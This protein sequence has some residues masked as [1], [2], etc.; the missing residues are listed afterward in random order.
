[1]M[2]AMLL[3]LASAA[4]A[5]VKVWLTVD[6][7]TPKG[8]QRMLQG[9]ELKS[10]EQFQMQVKVDRKAYVYVVQFFPDGTSQVLFP[11]EGEVTVEAEEQMRL[12]PEGYWFK[13]DTNAGTE[14]IYVIASER[15]ISQADKTTASI[16]DEVRKPKPKP[17]KKL[18]PD[19]LAKNEVGG[20]TM[21]TR[22]VLLVKESAEEPMQV[23][24][25]KDGVAIVLF[26]FKHLP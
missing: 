17:K 11:E 15:P 9:G 23:Q 20:L 8:L 7:K 14:N 1:M 22:G 5:K 13:L 18:P 19:A 4:D 21:K 16:L 3:L 2:T 12:P 24:A 26:S 10:G 25:D 6:A